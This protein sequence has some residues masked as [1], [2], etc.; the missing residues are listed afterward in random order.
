MN[1]GID[2]GGTNIAAALLSEKGEILTRTNIPVD[3]SLGAKSIIDGLLQVCDNLI[4]SSKIQPKSIGIGV[5]G[6]VNDKKGEVIF[7]PNLPLRQ[8]K[9]T[10]ELQ[11]LYGCPVRL[12]NDANCAAIGETF[13]GCVSGAKDVVFVTLGTGVGGAVIRDEKLLT[14]I[15]GAASEPGHMVIA[16]GGRLCGCGRQGCWETY[17]S[18][19]GLIRTAI[20][21]IQPYKESELWKYCDGIEEH[22]TGKAIFDAFRK[23]DEAAIKILDTYTTHLAAGITNIINILEPQMIIIGGGISNSWDC[24][25]HILTKKVEGEKYFRLLPEA[26]KTQIVKAQLG[27]DAGIIGAALL[28]TGYF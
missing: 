16:V 13:F 10:S 2:L 22:L 12:G 18:A 26:P 7:T 6:S 19:T 4:G 28:N 21:L 27:N 14:G 3:T 5:P 9:V 23:G 17:A 1:I 20:E 11:M 8:T 24:I 25:E 15:S